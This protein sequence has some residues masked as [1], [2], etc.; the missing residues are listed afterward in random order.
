LISVP[1]YTHRL[2]QGQRTA[3]TRR[4]NGDP[5]H[6]DGS[7]QPLDAVGDTP[8]LARLVALVLCCRSRPAARPHRLRHVR[9]V[10]RGPPA[11]VSPTTGPL[12]ALTG[13]SA[14][15]GKR[16]FEARPPIRARRF[17]SELFPPC[18]HGVLCRARPAGGLLSSARRR[19]RAP[20][21]PRRHEQP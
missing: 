16:G 19:D 12:S 17:F 8:L 15:G 20:A 18:N 2:P 3:E 4:L 13:P 7:C 14:L 21:D 9:A 11:P 1:H 5:R 10:P 6:H